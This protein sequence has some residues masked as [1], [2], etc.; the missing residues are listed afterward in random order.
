M[1]V[2]FASAK[3]IVARTIGGANDADQLTIAGNAINQ[4]IEEWNLRQKWN[5]L[6]ID[7][8]L[9]PIA[10]AAGQ[11]NY[12]LPTALREPYDARL[13][14]TNKRS[15]QYI[16]QRDIDR[17]IRD[18][19]VTGVPVY[20]NLFR[21]SN[22]FAAGTPASQAGWI[23]LYPT[24]NYNQ[25]GDLYVK[26]YRT[27][28]QPA[29]DTDYVDMPDRY[30][31]SLLTMAKYYFLVDK[32]AESARTDH[33]RQM[34]DKLFAECERDDQEYQDDDLALKA[35]VEYGHAWGADIS[36]SPMNWWP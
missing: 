3:I 5:F 8:S 23:R 36:N 30:I 20:Y 11:Q 18:Q 16:E 33:H 21:G 19:T 27:I 7:N 15:L 14:V 13:I 35:Q 6:L 25:A 34:A 4:A 26:Y 12:Q 29:L 22:D 24:P 2:T 28:S 10:I 9:S 32:D 1:A 17:V 31:Y